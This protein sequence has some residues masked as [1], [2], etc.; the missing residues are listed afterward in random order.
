MPL[1]QT[2]YAHSSAGRCVDAVPDNA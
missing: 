2:R 1:E